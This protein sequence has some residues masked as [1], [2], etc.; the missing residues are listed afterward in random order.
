MGYKF[1]V[2]TGT[3]DVVGNSNSGG[4][5]VTRVGPTTDRSIPRWAGN[6]SDTISGS[7]A[8]I[9]DGGAVVAQ[10][11]ITKKVIND[12]VTID[13]DNVMITDGISIEDGELVIE[14]DGELVIV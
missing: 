8:D 11:F 1:N 9:Q 14:E 7:K 10:A 13:S 4:T 5:G 2:F 3:L 12:N 6:S